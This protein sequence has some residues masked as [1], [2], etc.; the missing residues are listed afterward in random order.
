MVKEKNHQYDFMVHLANHLYWIVGCLIGS[1]IG[2]INIDF[3]ATKTEKGEPCLMLEYNVEPRY[4]Y[5]RNM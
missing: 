3:P 2:Q 5:H 1:L 4:D